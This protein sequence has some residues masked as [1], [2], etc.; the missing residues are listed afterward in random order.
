[1]HTQCHPSDLYLTDVILIDRREGDTREECTKYGSVKSVAIRE[2]TSVPPEEAVRI[3]V[4]FE[5]RESAI[6][7]KVDLDGRFFGGRTVISS[8]YDESDYAAG[9]LVPPEVAA[10]EA[11]SRSRFG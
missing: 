11:R 2:V 9:K 7:A 4:Y 5:E 10:R 8:Y 3:F 1:L 6:K